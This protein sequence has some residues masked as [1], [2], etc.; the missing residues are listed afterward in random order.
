MALFKKIAQDPD[1]GRGKTKDCQLCGGSGRYI[2]P[3]TGTAP[4]K[5]VKCPQCDGTGK[6]HI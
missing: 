6:R 4:A 5:E 3:K 2:V 1:E